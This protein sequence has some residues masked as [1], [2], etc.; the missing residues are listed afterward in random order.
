VTRSELSAR[1]A[2]IVA[3][4]T[5]CVFISRGHALNAIAAAGNGASCEPAQ[6]ASRGTSVTSL[7]LHRDRHGFIVCVPSGWNVSFQASSL[8]AIVEGAGAHLAI[9]VGFAKQIAIDDAKALEVAPAVTRERAP[10]L[11][12]S[13]AHKVGNGIVEVSGTNPARGGIAFFVSRIVSA[14]TLFYLYEA[15]A[16][17]SDVKHDLPIFAQVFQSFRIAQPVAAAGGAGLPPIYRIGPTANR[18]KARLK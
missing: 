5:I 11:T 2:G 9:R 14:G 10:S 15:D 17:Q 18:A 1:M 16:P 13:R 7:T 3:A 8:S 4:L 6:S 12:W